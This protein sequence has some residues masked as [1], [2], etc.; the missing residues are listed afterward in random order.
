MVV[1]TGIFFAP[2]VK[3]DKMRERE[4][5]VKLGMFLADKKERSKAVL[6]GQNDHEH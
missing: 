5:I 4:K 3:I 6:N 1:K 2:G